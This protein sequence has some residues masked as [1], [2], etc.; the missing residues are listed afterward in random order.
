MIGS[1]VLNGMAV[2][3]RNFIGSYFER[4]RLTTVQYPEERETLAENYRNFPFLVYDTD[5]AA[6]GLR[7][8]ACKICEKEC[9]PQCIL[10]VKSEDKK[11][12]YMGKP[13]FYPRIFDIDISVC[14][15]CQIC[16]EVCPFEAIKMDKVFELSRRERFDSLLMRKDELAKSNVYYHNIH[17]L[18][19]A[20]VDAKLAEAAEAKKKKT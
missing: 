16:V 14:M 11:P 20:E 9:P 8:V 10:I 2:T 19:A 18:E 1:G 12:D 7:C 15:S 4:D 6:A 13:Q 5:D 3:L 17:P